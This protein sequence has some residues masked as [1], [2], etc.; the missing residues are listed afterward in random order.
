MAFGNPSNVIPLSIAGPEAAELPLVVRGPDS[1][2]GVVSLFVAVTEAISATLFIGKEIDS[3]ASFP[4]Y[5]Q[6][7]WATG[8]PVASGS[9]ATSPLWIEGGL[10]YTGPDRDG[11]IPL[12]IVNIVDSG[13]VIG[14]VSFYTVA[15]ANFAS[16]E[17]TV[18]VS[19]GPP[20]PVSNSATL[21]MPVASGA[22]VGVPLYI[23]KRFGAITPLTITSYIISGVLPVIVSGA[24]GLTT[25]TSLLIKPPMDK[26]LTT[27]TRGF[28][29]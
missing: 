25:A 1:A 15:E 12:S 8:T 7:P 28:S 29:E 26:P 24:S 17:I 10:Y 20:V 9:V 21:L 19:G 11:S 18:A 22:S 16:G 4:L 2:S 6:S 13:N 5:L 27:F 23:E 14:N 3:N